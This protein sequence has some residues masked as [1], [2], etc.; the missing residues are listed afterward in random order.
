LNL[1]GTHEAESGTFETRLFLYRGFLVIFRMAFSEELS[2]DEDDIDET[3]AEY[4][5]QL[6][7]KVNKA[8]SSLRM[9]FAVSA[10]LQVV[11]LDPIC[12]FSFV[13]RGRIFS[14]PAPAFLSEMGV[15]LNLPLEATKFFQAQFFVKHL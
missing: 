12:V 1:G 15:V 10:T 13:A 7:A 8:N 5:E 2:S 6:E 14:F 9:P 3:S 11:N 4:L